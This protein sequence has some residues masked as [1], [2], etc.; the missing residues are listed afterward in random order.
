M[1]PKKQKDKTAG[2][3]EQ[4]GDTD[5][6]THLH[7][8]HDMLTETLNRFKRRVEQLRRDHEFLQNEVNQTQME[9]EEYLSYISERMQ[10]HQ[11]AIVTVNEQSQQELEEL[12]RQREE[13]LETYE[14]EGNGLKRE[15]L[16]KEKELALLN[17]E[18]AELKEFKQQL[19]HIAELEKEVVAARCRHSESMVAL[20]AGLLK[21]ME[22]HQVQADNKV[23]EF[24]LAAKKEASSCLLSH[25]QKM[26]EENQHLRE[27]LLHLIQRAHAQRSHQQQLQEQHRQLLLET[28][29]VQ[30][31]QYLPPSTAQ[32]NLHLNESE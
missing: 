4:T 12:R 31:L 1:P 3:S 18:L 13:T 25:T 14:K 17:L 19:G 26:S 16:E 32:K 8:E 7:K 23:Q 6:D 11:R 29:Y 20:K 22:R 5:P 30:K 21:E 24:A 10:K 15:I 2:D 27:E 9:N 28:E